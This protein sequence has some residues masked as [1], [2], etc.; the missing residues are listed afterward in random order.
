MVE[1]FAELI[2]GHF[3]DVEENNGI[4][5]GWQC[6]VADEPALR[7]CI[8]EAGAGKG[9]EGLSKDGMGE[10]EQC[11][12]RLG[13]EDLAA[14]IEDIKVVAGIKGEPR[15]S[16]VICKAEGVIYDSMPSTGNVSGEFE[17]RSGGILIL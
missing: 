9:G 17:A 15:K 14:T 6:G 12:I 8:L 5:T 16:A 7:A 4:G 13:P 1:G 10:V 11:S 2:D 3:L